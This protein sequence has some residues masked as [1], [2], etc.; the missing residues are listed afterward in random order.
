MTPEDLLA[1][2]NAA[3]ESRRPALFLQA[4]E[5]YLAADD[6]AGAVDALAL[7]DAARLRPRTTA[8]YRLAVAQAALAE[9]RLDDARAALATLDDAALAEPRRGALLRA[10]VL[11]ASGRPD[12]AAEALMG[13]SDSDDVAD[14][15]SLNDTI[16]GY[17]AAVDPYRSLARERTA[18]GTARG[19]WQLRTLMLD[20][21]TLSEQRTRLAAWLASHPEH[22][23]T[24]QPPAAV[25]AVHEQRVAVRRVGLLLPLSGPLGRAGKSVRDAF[26]AT[27]LLHRD[28]VGFTVAVYDAAAAP[29]G[30]LYEQAL[31]DGTDVLVGP[32]SKDAVATLNGLTPEIP[33]L[34]LNY[35]GPEPASPNLLQIGLA[36]EDEAT[37][38]ETWLAE[39]G[40]QRLLLLHN[41]DDWALRARQ[42]FASAW[43]RPLTVQALEDIRTVTESV[44]VAMRVSAS[45]D[46]HDELE[47]ILGEKLEFLPRARGDV[48][49]IVALVT[50]L[51]ASA[52]VPALKYHFADQVPVYATSQTIRGATPKTLQQLDGFR[53]SELPWFI[54]G[55]ASFRALDAA[56]NLDA[57][58]FAALY[59]LGVDAFRLAERTPLLVEGGAPEMLGSTGVLEF[60]PDG[61]V[62]RHLAR[63]VVRNGHTVDAATSGR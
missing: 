24:L 49:A 3:S 59:A 15:Q 29:L 4:A 37:T 52:L 7:V 32:L 57:N 55:D 19:W 42:A 20:S 25:A 50:Q 12:D 39:S 56:F 31:V 51:E 1:G 47:Q 16:W 44:G 34:A 9:G 17:L 33:V 36:I 35:L 6:P 48:D 62:I 26:I 18:S 2:A 11:S 41:A 21:F 43:N 61:R 22:P 27:Y 30:E 54:H 60:S 5:A 40:K 10:T 23:A 13:L 63:A 46:R 14:L 28:E 45:Q 53:I 8:R 38:L 58:P